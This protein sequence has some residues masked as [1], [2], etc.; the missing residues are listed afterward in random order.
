MNKRN[1]S[2]VVALL[3]LLLAI[4]LVIPHS[5]PVEAATP[6]LSK[7]KVTLAKGGKTTLKVTGTKKK[8]KWSSDKKKTATVSK[9]GMVTARGKGTAR[10]TA[11][12]GKKKLVCRVTVETPKLNKSRLT[13]EAGKTAALKV[14]G[15]KSK[16]K[17]YSSDRNIAT[18]NQ[19]GIVKGV[20]VGSCRVYAKANKATLLCV[21]YVKNDTVQ[22][23]IHTIVP[24]TPMPPS[25]D[26]FNENDARNNIKCISQ[27]TEKGIVTIVKNN[28]KYSVRL[29]IDC[30]YFNSTGAMVG[31]MSDDCYVLESG[32]EAALF[33]GNPYD[34]NYEDIKYSSYNVNI[35]CGKPYYYG[36]A[37]N[38]FCEGNFGSGNIVAAVKNNGTAVSFTRVAI[39]FYKNGNIVG[40]DYHYADVDSTGATDYLQFSFPYDS[41]YDTITPD[42]FKLYVNYSY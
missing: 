6:K 37:D 42:D 9:K 11:K 12:I 14:T 25:K 41:N 16:V 8:V 10:I 4:A 38:I 1:K 36:N 22:N 7:T 31:T 18:V 30:V 5:Q 17:W 3:S 40:Y 15:T 35:K 20:G 39:V 26:E 24:T 2:I 19:K 29:E 27:K 32:R 13:V 33:T 21:I 23:P 34:S 28:Y